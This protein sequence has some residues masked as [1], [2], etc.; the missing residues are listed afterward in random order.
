MH[1]LT[2]MELPVRIWSMPVEIPSPVRFDQDTV[3]ASYDPERA[4]GFWRIP[5]QCERVFSGARSFM[6][7]ASGGFSP[8]G[9]HQ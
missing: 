3:R 1:T 5:V 6:R 7:E 9:R 8:L 4:N 2:R